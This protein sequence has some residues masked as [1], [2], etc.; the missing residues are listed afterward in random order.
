MKKHICSLIIFLTV[1]VF[2]TYAK[3]NKFRYAFISNQSI[4]I[5]DF[6]E[7]LADEKVNG[8]T[9]LSLN[10]DKEIFIAES[11]FNNVKSYYY[12]GQVQLIYADYRK[13]INNPS[14]KYISS[15]SEFMKY[16]HGKI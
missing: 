16:V 6:A 1:C 13:D 12:A 10:S 15:W 7:K 9:V 5:G 8:T 2:S 4:V 3:S 11:G 14:L